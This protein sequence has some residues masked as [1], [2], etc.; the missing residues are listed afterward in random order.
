MMKRTLALLLVFIVSI[1]LFAG[2]GGDGNNSALTG[3]YTLVAYEQ[4]GEEILTEMMDMFKELG[5]VA[6]DFEMYLEF[7]SGGKFKLVMSDEEE[8]GTFKVNGTAVTLRAGSDDLKGIIEG[9]TIVIEENDPDNG[10]IKMVF[11][12]K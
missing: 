5:M 4:D 6:D 2:C 7:Q 3:K 11:E 8:K 9:D 1:S 12:K 10:A